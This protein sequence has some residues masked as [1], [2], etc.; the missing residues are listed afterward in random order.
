VNSV[1]P[2]KGE[3]QVTELTRAQRAI[4]RRVA[5]SRATVPHLEMAA[6]VGL[7]ETQPGTAALIGACARALRQVPRA[8]AAYRDGAFELYSRINVGV[9][10]MTADA[11]AL[12]TV[13]D[14][15]R[16][17]LPELEA[18]IAGLGERAA[19][20]ALTPP[21]LSG[22]TFSLTDLSA[23]EVA[24][25]APVVIPSHAAALAAGGV[26]A[27]PVV[28]DEAIVPGHVMTI[29]LACDNRILYSQEAARFLTAIKTEL[30]AQ[31]Q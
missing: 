15:D 17:S 12:A 21:E 31:A 27:A 28:R 4:A 26:R 23:T 29:T 1:T 30:E 20:G 18:E 6:E 10:T 8:N 13:L 9:V 2:N 19:A 3:T 11:Y 14:A 25:T 16:K 5:E 24:S 22:S 7:G